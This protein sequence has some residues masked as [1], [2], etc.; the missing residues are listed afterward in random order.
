MDFPPILFKRYVCNPLYCDVA[1]LGNVSVAS[2]LRGEF[3]GSG[4]EIIEKQLT[5]FVGKRSV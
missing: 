3:L 4:I 2:S 5:V 1:E